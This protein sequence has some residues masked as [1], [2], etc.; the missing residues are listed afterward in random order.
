MYINLK[1]QDEMI[2][3]INDFNIETNNGEKIT[4]KS[5][6]I[7]NNLYV[8]YIDKIIL[9]IIFTP[10]Y[11]FWR[12]AE[13]EDLIQ[14]ARTAVYMSILKKQF[15]TKRG[16]PFNFFSTVVSNTLKNFTQKHNRNFSF[17]SDTDISKLYNNSSL[18]Y[19]QNL[20]KN[21]I[22]NDVI[23]LL[24]IFFNNK[25]K[26]QNL[27]ILLAQY[28]QVNSSGKF[29]KK[30]F[31]NYAKGHNFSPAIV[32]TFFSYLKRFAIHQQI[33]ELLCLVEYIN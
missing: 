27:T 21:I 12:F 1:Q 14:E 22:L 24:I 20:D 3:L 30:H 10:Q 9:G 25:P 29:I 33:Q 19:N 17:K 15:D 6:A 13:N 31:I 23:G 4:R 11:S 18:T 16:G 32:N 5:D 8:N 2:S 7:M 26:F 28:I